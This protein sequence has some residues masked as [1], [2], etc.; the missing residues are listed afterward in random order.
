MSNA[1]YPRAERV[2]AAIKHVLADEVGRLKDPR[3][4]FVT[5]TDVTVSPDLRHARAFYT[6]YGEDADREATREGLTRAA[7]HLRSVVA[8]EVRLRFTPTLDFEEDP[9]PERARHLDRLIA[10]LHRDTEGPTDEEE[11]P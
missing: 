8:R 7:R 4:G 10:Q 1:S 5:I 3:V 2:R 9:L 6:V 11:R